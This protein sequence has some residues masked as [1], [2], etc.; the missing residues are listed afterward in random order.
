MIELSVSCFEYPEEIKE[1]AGKD[2]QLL[3]TSQKEREPASCW[4]KNTTSKYF[5]Q[6]IRA[7]PKPAQASIHVET[8]QHRE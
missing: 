6:K 1:L 2:H 8:G 5:C 4:K 3:L 7:E